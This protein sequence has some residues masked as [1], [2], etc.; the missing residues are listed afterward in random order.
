MHRREAVQK[1]NGFVLYEGASLYDSKPIVVIATGFAKDSSNEK[2]GA[3]IQT[4]ILR[5]DEAPNIAL[6]AGRD[7]SVCGTC[8]HRSRS[9]GGRGTCYVQMRAPCTVWKAYR[10][11]TY[12][13]ATHTLELAALGA[14][15]KLRLGSYGDPAAVPAHVWRAF[16]ARAETHRGY[17]HGWRGA[18]ELRELCMASADSVAD[19]REAWADGWRTFR[20]A[21]FGD[22]RRERGE[23]RCPASAEAGK[24]LQCAECPLR[25]SGAADRL[26]SIVIQAHGASKRRV[27]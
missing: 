10:R 4:W 15:R 7:T 21:P 13:R 5:A 11:G 14:G 9:S 8:P 2:T 27:A 6:R 24:R 26:P 22:S 16:T 12:P 20:V 19:V 25:C 23:A 17:S 3:L 1:R 18:P